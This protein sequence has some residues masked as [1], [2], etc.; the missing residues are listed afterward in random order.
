MDKIIIMNYKNGDVIA[1]DYT[2]NWDKENIWGSDAE[3]YIK[4][5]IGLASDLGKNGQKEVLKSDILEFSYYLDKIKF[6]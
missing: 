5:P 6:L 1:Y 4:L 3:P 2:K